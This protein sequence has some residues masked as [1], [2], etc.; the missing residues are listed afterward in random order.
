MLESLQTIDLSR[1]AIH[2]ADHELPY[3]DWNGISD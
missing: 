2:P 3:V 1:S